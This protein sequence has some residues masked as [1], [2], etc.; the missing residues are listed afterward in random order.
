MNVISSASC[1]SRSPDTIG[2]PYRSN[3][4][5]AWKNSPLERVEHSGT[6][7]AVQYRGSILPLVRLA[8]HLPSTAP[9]APGSAS[10]DSIQVIVYQDGDLY[11]GLV[12]GKIHDIIEE[13]FDL[14]PGSA[15]MGLRGSAIVQCQ[16]TDLVDVPA[17]LATAGFNLSQAA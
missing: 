3:K 15:G 13:S 6:R 9:G 10:D 16:I 2:S 11:I 8:N 12:V 5:L 14:Q 7:E 4:P 17:A 1:S